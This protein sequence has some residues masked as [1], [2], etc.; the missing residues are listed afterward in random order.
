M[1]TLVVTPEFLS[2]VAGA[3][4]SWFF[5]YTP[6]LNTAY[7]ALDD[8]AKKLI[9]LGLEVLVTIVLFV[10]ACYQF[11]GIQGF[12]CDRQTAIHFVWML[13]AAVGG[14][15]LAF[16]GATVTPTAVVDAKVKTDVSTPIGRKM[17]G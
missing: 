9:M 13:A 1:D 5:T 14:N 12:A 16:K 15:F 17:I 6:K 10:L 7:A 2:L 8:G 11:L 3:L 4:L